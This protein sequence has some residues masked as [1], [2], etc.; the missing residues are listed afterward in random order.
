MPE[1][2]TAR[3]LKVWAP[4]VSPSNTAGELHGANDSGSAAPVSEHWK[5]T[6]LALSVP[7]KRNMA[8]SPLGFGGRSMICVSGATTSPPIGGPPSQF[9]RWH[10]CGSSVIGSSGPR[11][12]WPRL[13]PASTLARPLLGTPA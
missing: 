3:T 12:P 8:T 2:S 5:V 13:P 9:T 1:A 11:L 4:G 7:V 6:S 10:C